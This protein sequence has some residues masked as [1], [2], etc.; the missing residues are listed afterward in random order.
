MPVSANPD[1]EPVFLV[2]GF[3]RIP[4]RAGLHPEGKAPGLQY[5]V[6]NGYHTVEPVLVTVI[7]NKVGIQ[8]T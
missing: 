4:E 7:K 5:L 6:L 3:K 8:L 1:A 2:T